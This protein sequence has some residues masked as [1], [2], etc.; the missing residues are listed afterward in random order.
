LVSGEELDIQ[1]LLDDLQ[2]L[3]PTIL[4]GP[5]RV[6]NRI[7]DKVHTQLAGNIMSRT[8]FNYAYNAKLTQLHTTGEES[9]PLWDKLVFTKLANLI[10]GRVRLIISGSAPLSSNVQDFLRICFLAKV[11]QG[12]GLTESCCLGTVSDPND[13]SSGHVGA[14]VVSV[15]VKLVDV[16]EMNYT[17]SGK[18]QQGEVCLRGP[19]IF[20]GY[21]KMPEKTAEDIDRDGWFH[22][23]DIGEWVYNG[24]LKIIDRKK[25]IFKL[26]QGEYVAAEYLETVYTRSP[27]VE[28]IFVFGDS[29]KNYLVAI[30]VPDPENL[31]PAAA[32]Q[33]IKDTDIKELCRNPAIKKF[34]YNSLMK[35]A[36][37]AKLKGFEKVK[38]IHLDHEQWTPENGLLTPTLKAKRPELKKKIRKDN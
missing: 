11:V 36:E 16:P 7:Y 14:P 34:V 1:G 10:G 38:N 24:T 27:F 32:Q 19:G 17:S 21:Y 13:P 2:T 25:N 18:I 30:V 23:G 26:A 29:L 20:K 35:V 28:K 6:F 33:G 3:R 12:Y 4:V 8:L 22:T 15:E 5:P 31:I 9:S 37:K